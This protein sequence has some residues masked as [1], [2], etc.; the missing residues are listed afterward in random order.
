MLKPKWFKALIAASFALLVASGAAA[1]NSKEIVPLIPPQ[2]VENDGKVEVLE[3]FSY[4]CPHCSSL[5]PSLSAW[6]KRQP[7]D[8]KVKRIPVD[9]INGYMGC[10][11]LYFTLEAMGQLDRLH[12]KIFD[13]FH[14]EHLILANPSILNKWL[15]KNGVDPRK[16]EEMQKSFS[17]DTNIKRVR[18][19]NVDYKISSVP[20]MVVNGRFQLS[21]VAGPDRMFASIDQL[22]VEARGGKKAVEVKTSAA[23]KP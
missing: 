18:K 15:E 6:I 2:P 5:D 20:T 11:A 21:P 16:F 9:G 17:V 7:A 3:F 4:A 23:A 14:V 1:Q 10:A 19:M 12:G 22:I 13:A 8:V